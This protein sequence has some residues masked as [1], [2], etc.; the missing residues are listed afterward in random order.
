MRG[1]KPKPTDQKRLEGNP[2]KRQLND[3]EPEPEVAIPDCPEHLDPE[4][5]AE[6][7]R[8]TQEPPK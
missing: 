4:A 2:G 6:W 3:Q 8:V 7:Q 1:R 5:R